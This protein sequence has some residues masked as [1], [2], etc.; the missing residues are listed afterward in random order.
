VLAFA[1]EALCFFLNGSLSRGRGGLLLVRVPAALTAERK[2]LVQE[3]AAGFRYAFGELAMRRLIWL[4]AAL[5]LFTAPWQSL[6]PIYA[7]ETFAGTSKTLGLL[8][9]AVGLGALAA[10]GFLAVRPSVRG[11]GRNIKS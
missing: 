1:G 6:M 3:I 4:L 9:G 5:S 10:T 11:L 8:I 7:G 2:S